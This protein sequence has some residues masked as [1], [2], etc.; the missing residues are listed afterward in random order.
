MIQ[1]ICGKPGAGKTLFTV[2]LIVDEL[3][4]TRRPIVTNVPLRLGA[5]NEYCQEGD[6]C[7]RVFLLK[8][9][10]L[11]AFWEHRGPRRGVYR[12]ERVGNR[13][14]QR[15]EV[16]KDDIGVLYVLD[17]VQVV[18]NARDWATLG[19]GALFYL[20]Q[21]RKLGDDVI[22][23]SQ[24]VTLVDKQFRLVTQDF[25]VISNNAKKKV[26]WFRMPGVF[27]R[28]TYLQAPTGGNELPVV[29]GMFRLDASGLGSLY[30]TAAGVGVVGRQADIGQRAKGLPLWM[31]GVFLILLVLGVYYAA[32]GGVKGVSR[33]MGVQGAKVRPAVESVIS[34]AMPSVV[35]EAVVTVR[36]SPPV[37]TNVVRLVGIMASGQTFS[38]ALSDG[39]VLRREDV[40]YVGRGFV[41]GRDGKVYRQ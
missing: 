16:D 8:D 35:H 11:G 26:G 24:A 19:K 34:N 40:E 7:S 9:E 2:R 32:V 41:V 20:S 31:G 17:E 29:R 25:T 5:L 4:R 37:D 14:H 33:L 23:S 3:R 15:Y 27:T 1:A 18:F 36:Q 12:A 38:A 39:R 21:H 13:E 6:V 10:E 28:A 30:D 22:W